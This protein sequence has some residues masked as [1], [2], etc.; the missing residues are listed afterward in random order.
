MS[1]PLLELAAQGD[2]RIRIQPAASPSL[3]PA[4]APAP[5]E[6]YRFHFDMTRCIGCKCCEVACSEQN[7]NPPG[8]RWRRVGEI[9]AGEFPFTQRFHLSMGCNHCLEAACLH[10]CPVDAYRKDPVTGL[11]LHDAEA[12]IGCQYCTWNCPYGVPQFNEERGVVGKCDMCYGRLEESRAPACV[13]A[14][15]EQAI[16]IEL[17]NI[18]AWKQDYAAQANAPGMPSAQTTLST[19]RIT[20]PAEDQLEFQKADYHRVRPESPHW[21]LVI[22]LVLTQMSVGAVASLLGFPSLAGAAVATGAG[23]LALGASLFHLGRPIFAWR[24]LRMW[25]RS[26]LS[27][28]VLCFSLFAAF[29]SVYGGALFLGMPFAAP[30]GAAAVAA[31]VAGILSSACIYRVPARPAWNS[32]TTMAEFLLTSALLG[33]L[34]AGCFVSVNWRWTA[35]AAAAQFTVQ[36][37]KLVR[38]GRS[39]EFEL[40]QSARLLDNELRPLFLLRLVLLSGA[41]AP[42]PF[43]LFLAVAG[44]V[45]GRYLFFVSVVPRN[46]AASFFGGTR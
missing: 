44:E 11:V 45:M 27:R 13:Q 17:V 24:A 19:T 1:L 22:M 28:E 3:M 18:D 31:G 4:R 36:L 6:Q 33:P 9:E 34:L 43:G 26:W 12:C 42:S 38:L 14:C 7:N 5:G 10:G 15:P 23:Y 40:R 2:A 41:L 35:L 32:W 30:A 20:L 8:I 39:A 25:R 29:T 16:Q 21:P 46:I 37:A